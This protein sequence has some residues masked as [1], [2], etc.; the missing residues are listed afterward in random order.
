[1][2]EVTHHGEAFHRGAC[3]KCHCE[4]NFC[5]KDINYDKDNSKFPYYFS[6][7]ECRT[8]WCGDTVRVITFT[9]ENNYRLYQPSSF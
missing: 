5:L 1:M 6:C 8:V 7:P 9:L 2:V 4:F 3:K